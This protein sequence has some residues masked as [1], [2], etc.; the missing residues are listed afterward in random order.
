M[1]D[2]TRNTSTGDVGFLLQAG[3][4]HGGVHPPPGVARV[5]AAV[6]CP[7]D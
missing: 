6:L 5:A 3:A 7:D 2:E 1:S 4:V